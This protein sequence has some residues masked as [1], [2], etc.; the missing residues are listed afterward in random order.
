MFGKLFPAGIFKP[1]PVVELPK[2]GDLQYGYYGRIEATEA[3]PFAKLRAAVPGLGGVNNII[4]SEWLKFAYKGKILLIPR[5]C[6]VRNVSRELVGSFGNGKPVSHNGKSYT[7][8]IISGGSS[9]VDD[10]EY[11]RF[12]GPLVGGAGQPRWDNYTFADI[13][14]SNLAN[15]APVGTVTANISGG[16]GVVRGR[17]GAMTWSTH[18]NNSVAIDLGWRPVLEL[19]P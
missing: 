6:P 12:L 4:D 2:F 3:V 18:P 5:A 9:A 1:A 11:T 15:K 13:A 7:I 17:T 19:I 10:S 14:Q 16:Q 8:W